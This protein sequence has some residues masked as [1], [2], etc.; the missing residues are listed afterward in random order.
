M[1][2]RNNEVSPFKDGWLSNDDKIKYE[3][4]NR[5]NHKIGTEKARITRR[6]SDTNKV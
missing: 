4:Q 5:E 3:G 1:D 2:N 6:R